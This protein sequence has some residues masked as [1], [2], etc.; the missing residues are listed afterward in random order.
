MNEKFRRLGKCQRNVLQC[1]LYKG[2]VIRVMRDLNNS[3][4]Q[5]TLMD[6]SGDNWHFDLTYRLLQSLGKKRIFSIMTWV[7]SLNQEEITYTIKPKFVEELKT[8][9]PNE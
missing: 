3:K 5:I 4:D 8:I 7:P 6:D 9:I 2:Q 1:M